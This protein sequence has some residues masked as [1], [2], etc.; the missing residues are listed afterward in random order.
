VDA[1]FEKECFE[2]YD[3]YREEWL[4]DLL[5]NKCLRL[6]KMGFQD[7]VIGRWI[8]TSEVALRVLFLGERRLYNVSSRIQRLHYMNF[9]SH[10]F[11]VEC[12]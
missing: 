11:V 4:E 6:G 8:K 5:I 12:E 2:V 10:R 1:G 9:I 3:S 7:Y